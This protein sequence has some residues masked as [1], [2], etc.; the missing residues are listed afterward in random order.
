MPVDLTS[1]DEPLN[2]E[3]LEALARA[4]L[5]KMAYDYYSS[6]AEDEITLLKNRTA[7]STIGLRPRMLVDVSNRS[8]ATTVMGE[9]VSMPILVAPTAFHA[10]AH[11]DRELATTRACGRLN[12]VMTLS[13]LATS[14]IEE[15]TQAASAPV[16]FQ[17][18]VYKDRGITRNLIER[19][20]SHGCKALVVTVDSP[21]LGRRERDVRNRFHL[22][23]HLELKNLS[24]LNLQS[25]PATQGGSGLAH[26]ISSLYDVSLTWKDLEWMASLTKLP[27]L[28]KGILRADDACHALDFGARGI[29]VSNHGGRQLDTA[30][31]SIRALPEVVQA[32]E[33]K[34]EVFVD[35]GIRR[36]TDILKAIALGARAVLIGRPVLWGLAINGEEGVVS[37]L[38]MLRHELDL[39]MVLS[40]CPT[41]DSI[42]EDL[43][44]EQPL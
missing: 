26:Y 34:A 32:V 38:E 18:Y 35:G 37:A 41:L 28:V 22:P 23:P 3:E 29:V 10:L 36:G 11:P 5:P 6:G 4:K 2:A 24:P 27:V 21:M 20:E 31:P 39:A 33:G 8:M 1:Y 7:F 44:A 42:T 30:V 12:T 15:V 9:A 14:S 17:L 16:W 25:V 13:T 43:I 19:A 40:G